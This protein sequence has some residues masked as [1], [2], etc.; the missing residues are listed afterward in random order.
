MDAIAQ[1]LSEGQ[2]EEAIA[3][4]QDILRSK[5]A[6]VEVRA[7]LIE[8]LCLD[9]QLERADEMLMSLAKYQPAWLA[10]AA[11][12]RQL[13]RAEHARQ[14]LVGGQLADD[15][16]A[17]SGEALEAL[18]QVQAG[19]AAGDLHAAEVAATELEQ[20]RS[21]ARF[22]VGEA[23][24]DLRDCDDSLN[25][26]FEGLGADGH[27]YLWAWSS[28]RTI[29]FHP[30]TT[31]VERIWRRADVELLDGRRGE[32]FVPL[33]YSRSLTPHQKLGRETDWQNHSDSLVTGLGLK[34]FLVG[35]E[36]VTLDNVS[37][38][39]RTDVPEEGTEVFAEP[40]TAGARED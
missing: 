5:P 16:V 10:G 28:I 14:A 34:L 40:A 15:V 17:T 26:F 9:G 38:I 22:R 1:R 18:V 27:Y 6:A 25:G 36:A 8:L 30:V 31:P 35:D 24:G 3:R 29:D 39:E 33:T 4:A 37:R 21:P 7:S 13:M 2:L 11:N 23:E 19:L 20:A 12:L 32:I